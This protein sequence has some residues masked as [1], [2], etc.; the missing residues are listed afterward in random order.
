MTEAAI[1]IGMSTAF[2]S[3][4]SGASDGEGVEGG[5]AIFQ[6]RPLIQCQ[7]A[8]KTGLIISDPEGSS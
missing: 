4:S 7:V 1:V 8:Q 2:A 6:G 3:S 5:D